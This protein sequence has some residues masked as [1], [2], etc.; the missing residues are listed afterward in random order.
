MTDPVIF[1]VP[2]TLKPSKRGYVHRDLVTVLEGTGMTEQGE[3]IPDIVNHPRTAEPTVYITTDVAPFLDAIENRHGSHPGWNYRMI[4]TGDRDEDGSVERVRLDRFGWTERHP[5]TPRK[6]RPGC[7]RCGRTNGDELHRPP[8]PE[9]VKRQAMHMVWDPAAMS[10]SADT[11]FLVENTHRELMRW[12]MDFRAFHVEQDIPLSTSF[13]GAAAKFLRD[14]RFY[15][16][17]RRRVPRATNERARDFLPGMHTESRA[18][19]IRAY[20]GAALDQ[21]R[22]FHHVV[23]QVELPN[24]DNLFAR[25]FFTDPFNAPEYWCVPG[26]ELF[27]RTI[28]Q[29]GLVFLGVRL[30]KSGKNL[31]FRVPAMNFH[32]FKKIA[33][34]TNEVDHAVSH[35]LLIEGMY[36]ALTS[37]TA[38]TGLAKYGA[39][40]LHQI[41]TASPERA[42]WLKPTLHS[43]YGILGSRPR[44][45]MFGYRRSDKG[46]PREYILGARVFNVKHVETKGKMQTPTANVPQLGVIQAEVRRRTLD[47]ANHLRSHGV[48]VTHV[49]ADGLHAIG[50]L[51]LDIPD[52]WTIEP[53]T[54]LRYIDDASWVCD[55]GDHLPGRARDGVERWRIRQL[56]RATGTPTPDWKSRF[57]ARSRPREHETTDPVFVRYDSED[58]T[59]DRRRRRR[60][61]AEKTFRENP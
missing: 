31:P 61:R 14:P 23:Q 4:R 20:T 19:P 60:E 45:L 36:A 58:P 40:A 7:S 30:S 3:V 38:D 33:L 9:G 46:D 11:R 49:H 12:A 17:A 44:R 48:T 34:W 27:D 28:K 32:G 37:T 59:G 25:G 16:D 22:A 56:A 52:G 41:D 2:L 42:K 51:P 57:G 8:Y 26:D 13:A 6:D 24:A 5:F 50:Q 39:W 35:G 53:V 43:V 1:E 21:K 29:P 54:N 18:D 10:A 15:P 55:E 47:L